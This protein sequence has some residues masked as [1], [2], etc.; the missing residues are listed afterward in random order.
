M[1]A[2]IILAGLGKLSWGQ[3]L[4]GLGRQGALYLLAAILLVVPGHAAGE[5]ILPP[6]FTARVYVTGE[7]FD[8]SRGVRGIPAT[9]TLALDDAG[10]LYLARTGRRYFGGEA[11]DL[12]PIYRIPLGGARVTPDSEARY[13]YG[14]PV[15]NA[16]VAAVRA[17]REL[18]LTTFDRDRK[19]GVVYRLLDGRAEFFA[20]GTP[21]RGAPP[22]LRQPEG[23]AI[24]AAGNLYVA[25]REAGVVVKLDVSGRVVDPRYVSVT[26]PRVLAMDG[27]A[28]LWIGSDG[29]AE[30]PWQQGPGEIWKVGPDRAVT[31]VLRGPV[32]AGISLGPGG[33]LYV[34][35]R[36]AGK[37]FFI[38]REGKPAEFASFT[39][40]DAPRS[41]SFAPATPETR[42]A[43]IAGDLFVVTISRGA[44]PI[45]EVIRIS[46]PFDEF[47]RTHAAGG[48]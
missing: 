20:G 10:T 21:P 47:A 17:G 46:G 29:S 41:L 31:V 45:N 32:P 8:T 24:D 4:A 37:I 19:V 23:A 26:R 38:D 14:P 48:D 44:W 7:G 35:D 30:A 13:L 6:G 9:S 12:W 27:K 34:A 36:H 22:L 1:M 43:G 28:Q 15:P 42:K 25:D 18:L 39:D 16:Q 5:L 40:G 11:E 2:P 3:R 33:H